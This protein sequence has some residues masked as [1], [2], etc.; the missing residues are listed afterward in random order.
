MLCKTIGASG[1][2]KVRLE[3][4]LQPFPPTQNLY[5]YAFYFFSNASIEFSFRSSDGAEVRR[6][7][8]CNISNLAT[9]STLA[10][11]FPYRYF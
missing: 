7:L 1:G 10:C 6:A 9:Y 11:H 3:M 2:K 4:M 8:T 5:L